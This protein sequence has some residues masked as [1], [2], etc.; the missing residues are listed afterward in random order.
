MRCFIGSFLPPAIQQE[1]HSHK[2]GLKGVRWTKHDRYHLTFEFHA[3]VDPEC[4]PDLLHRVAELRKSFPVTCKASEWSG[5]PR[6]NRARVII[7][8]IEM[9]K[10]MKS[11][12]GVDDFQ[13]HV[14]VGYA[15][16]RYVR[17]PP[18][19]LQIEFVLDEVCLVESL[20]GQYKLVT[21]A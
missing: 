21:E 8:R 19:K 9:A 7:A 10:R 20:N 5:F 16:Q 11:L 6:P 15:R 17:V 18:T 2:P 13:P 1:L 4:V 3:D 12:L 14:T